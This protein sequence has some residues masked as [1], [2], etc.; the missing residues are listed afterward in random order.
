MGAT[1]AVGL[2]TPAGAEVVRLGSALLQAASASDTPAKT[3]RFEV[4]MRSPGSGGCDATRIARCLD[5]KSSRC[6]A[7]PNAQAR[8]LVAARAGFR[9]RSVPTVEQ[10]LQARRAN[11]CEDSWRASPKRLVPGAIWSSAAWHGWCDTPRPLDRAVRPICFE[12]VEMLYYAVVFF[13]IALIAALFGFGGI[14]A[15]AAGIAKI[16]FVV[17]LIVALVTFVLSLARR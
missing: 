12:E 8:A 11:P 14:A 15:G 6:C 3:S 7:N 10:Q 1:T 9:C 5:E 4:L 2:F 17:F 13:I 16:L